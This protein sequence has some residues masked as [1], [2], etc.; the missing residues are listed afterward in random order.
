MSMTVTELRE[1]LESIEADGAGDVPVYIDPPGPPTT[2]RAVY[3]T[4]RDNPQT[5]Y[6]EIH[7]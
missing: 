7:H 5:D 2:L 6:V 1:R 4:E 3:H